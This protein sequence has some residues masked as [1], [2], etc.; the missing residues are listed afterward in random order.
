MIR[1]WDLGATLVPMSLHHIRKEAV[2]PS[3]G[4]SEWRHAIGSQR[5]GSP[6]RRR[7]HP[8]L[9]HP[10]S[11]GAQARMTGLRIFRP[12]CRIDADGSLSPDKL[13]CRTYEGGRQSLAN[14][15]L[16]RCKKSTSAECKRRAAIA[17]LRL[18]RCVNHTGNVRQVPV[19]ASFDQSRRGRRIRECP[20]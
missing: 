4:L 14:K 16:L 6:V 5:Q 1:T 3:A 13:P 19:A 17:E 2:R 18:E 12:W 11:H 15:R 9:G 10:R 8:A 20:E 7:Y